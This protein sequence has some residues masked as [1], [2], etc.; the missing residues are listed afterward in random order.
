M[1][2]VA[3]RRVVA[4]VSYITTLFV[5]LLTV[6]DSHDPPRMDQANVLSCSHANTS[7]ERK[8][9]APT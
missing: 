6:K 5:D 8:K 7:W 2:L 4:L 1:V 3:E 9:V